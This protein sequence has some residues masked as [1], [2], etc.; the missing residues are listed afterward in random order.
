VFARNGAIV[1][2]D[3]DAGMALHYFS[4]PKASF[5]CS[6]AILLN[7]RRFTPPGPGHRGCKSNPGK[8]ATT[9][10]WCIT[11]NGRRAEF[12]ARKHGK[13]VPVSYRLA[14]RTWFYDAR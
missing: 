1:P 7:T 13:E 14:D 8:I 11:W 10:G 2:L 4:R 12:E 6:R 3:A 5:S 9:S